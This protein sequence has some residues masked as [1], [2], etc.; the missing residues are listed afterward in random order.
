MNDC[1]LPED[2]AIGINSSALLLP[3]GAISIEKV[4]IEL[5]AP[6]KAVILREDAPNSTLLELLMP[7]QLNN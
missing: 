6:N 5:S 1:K 7:M 4:R 2:L 3:L